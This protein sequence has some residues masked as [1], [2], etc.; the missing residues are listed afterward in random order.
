[1][2]SYCVMMLPDNVKLIKKYNNST[3]IVYCYEN[4]ICIHSRL[5]P[6]YEEAEA[7]GVEY[8]DMDWDLYG[9]PP[10]N[11]KVSKYYLDF[12]TKKMYV[13]EK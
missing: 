6:S 11:Y 1:M 2:K 12:V 4:N 7:F 9:F 8:L 3:R 10:E 5:M 13:K